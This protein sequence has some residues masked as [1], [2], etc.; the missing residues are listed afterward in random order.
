MND[1]LPRLLYLANY[2]DRLAVPRVPGVADFS[3]R[4]D[5]GIVLLGSITENEITKG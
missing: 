2:D 3:N 4:R 5:M 1:R